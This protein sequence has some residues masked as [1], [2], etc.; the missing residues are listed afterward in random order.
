MGPDNR[1]HYKIY[2]T[3]RANKWLKRKDGSTLMIRVV[4]NFSQGDGAEDHG[5]LEYLLYEEDFR[6]L[7]ALLPPYLGRILF[8]NEHNWIYDGGVLTVFEEEQVADFICHF[9]HGEGN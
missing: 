3:R 6:G 2:Q 8:D 4:P 5:I 1:M 9:E 7:N